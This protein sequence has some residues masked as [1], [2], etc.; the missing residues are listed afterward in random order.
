MNTLERLEAGFNEA[1]RRGD[2]EKAR[3]IGQEIRRL[4]SSPPEETAPSPQSEAS[5]VQQENLVALERRRQW[6]E[7]K[8]PA[9]RAKLLV[10]TALPKATEMVRNVVVEGGPIAVGQIA[11]QRVA[12]TPGRMLGGALGGFIG[13]TANQLGEKI[14][15]DRVEF[16][17]GR[18]V[19]NAIAGALT[20]QGAKRNAAVNASAEMVRS[21]IDE[22]EMPSM[23]AVGQ[24]AAMGYVAGR[25]SQAM[26]GRVLTPTDALMEYRNN[27]FRVLRR[28][29]VVVNP[30]E[31]TRTTGGLGSIAGSSQL[32]AAASRKNQAVWQRLARDE[33]GIDKQPRPFRRTTIDGRGNVVKGDI[34]LAIQR[35][36]RPYDE[37]RKISEQARRELDGFHNGNRRSRRSLRML[38]GKN[39]QEIDALLGAN[40]NLDAL[41]GIRSEIRDIGAAMKRGDP[42]AYRLLQAARATEQAIESRLEAAAMASGRRNLVNQLKESRTQLAKIYAVRDAVNDVTGLIDI[43]ELAGMRATSS[44]PGRMLTGNLAKMADFAEAFGRNAVEAVSAAVES[45][46]AV[47]INYSARQIAQGRASGPL[48]AGVPLLSRGAKGLLLGEMLQDRF[49]QPQ[50]MPA[51]ARAPDTVV[52]NALMTFGRQGLFDAE[53]DAQAQQGR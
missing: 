37:I 10:Q 34:D 38:R 11:G 39:Q 13:A 47:S 7:A 1:R 26:T 12:G 4:Q 14:W 50:F 21:L 23:E 22:N 3:V 48:S 17:P 2:D 45:P 5:R 40:D 16:E 52:R 35:A 43:N 31:L 15:G 53:E 8:N 18:I 24:A 20:T 27:T 36:S 41:K 25:V 30:Q 19:S 51:I 33:L 42:E 9:Q 46:Q 29:G 6:Q 44:R 28:E 32:N 49:A